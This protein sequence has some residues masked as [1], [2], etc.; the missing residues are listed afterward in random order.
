M[1]QRQPL[2]ELLTN[3]TFSLM[4]LDL[5]NDTIVVNGLLIVALGLLSLWQNG[6]PATEGFMQVM[7]AT[8]GHTEMER[9]VLEQ[10]LRDSDKATRELKELRIRYG[11]LVTED[12]VEGRKM[13][14]FG[15]AG[16][17]VSLRKS[18]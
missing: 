8:R 12:A 18:R 9:L 3:V 1:C 4:S 6:V 15:T 16:E 13:Q 17:T 7:M 5:W 2:N 11:E 10:E 14:G